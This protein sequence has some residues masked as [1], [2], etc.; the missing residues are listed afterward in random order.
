[1]A[2][3]PQYLGHLEDVGPLRYL[4]YVGIPYMAGRGENFFSTP[5]GPGILMAGDIDTD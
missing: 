2:W 4:G 3:N 1:M 5:E